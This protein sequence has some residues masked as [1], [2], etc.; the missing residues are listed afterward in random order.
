MTRSVGQH[1]GDVPRALVSAALALL[2]EGKDPG[3]R[4]VARRA[5]VSPAAPYH[6]F[7]GKD[8]LLTE[9]AREGFT[10]LAAAQAAVGGTGTD[11]L[12]AMTAAY[13]RFGWAH[14]THYR[15]MFAVPPHERVGESAA[16]LQQ[17][18]SRTFDTLVDTIAEANPALGADEAARRALMTWSLAHGLVQ[19][20]TWNG[21]PGDTPTDNDVL[22]FAAGRAARAIAEAAPETRA[23]TRRTPHDEEDNDA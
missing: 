16:A 1:H 6:H 18:G 3:L 2:E 14:P 11:R 17:V 22:A 12:E 5:D 4:A 7:A 9:V 20:G 19:L 10:A 23:M 21:L 8:G 15:V 13:V